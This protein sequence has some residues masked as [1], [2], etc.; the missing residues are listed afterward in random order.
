[1]R[2]SSPSSA[3]ASA[4]SE[5]ATHALYT[6][7]RLAASFA[8]ALSSWSASVAASRMPLSGATCPGN[9]R[10]LSSSPNSASSRFTRPSVAAHVSSPRACAATTAS[11]VARE[12]RTSAAASAGTRRRGTSQRSLT[13]PEHSSAAISRS[14]ERSTYARTARRTARAATTATAAPASAPTT[15]TFFLLASLISREEQAVSKIALPVNHAKLLD[16]G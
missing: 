8:Y 5:N 11:S 1:M 7:S 16:H 4:V 10:Q 15:T 2:A 6:S 3:L 12:R 13:G 9:V 14:A